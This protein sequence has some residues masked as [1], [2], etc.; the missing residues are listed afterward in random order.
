MAGLAVGGAAL[1]A[2]AA[3][4]GKEV[5]LTIETPGQPVPLLQDEAGRF[6][7][8][9]TVEGEVGAFIASWER[10]SDGELWQPKHVS[11]ALQQMPRCLDHEWRQILKPFT[12]KRQM[13]RSKKWTWKGERIAGLADKKSRAALDACVDVWGEAA[14][15]LEWAADKKSLTVTI[16]VDLVGPGTHEVWITTL[17]RKKHRAE[18]AVGPYYLVSMER[19]VFTQG[20]TAKITV[21]VPELPFDRDTPDGTPA[22]SRSWF[23]PT[24]FSALTPLP[25]G[26]AR[27]GAAATDG[28][29][30]GDTAGARTGGG[31]VQAE[32]APADDGTAKAKAED[33]DATSTIAV[34][35]V[36]PVVHAAPVQETAGWVAPRQPANLPWAA[37]GGLAL[38]LL[39]AVPS[40]LLER[41]AARGD[42]RL[43]RL[44]R[45]SYAPPRQASGARDGEPVDRLASAESTTTEG[46]DRA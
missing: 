38:A 12:S 3:K 4:D 33:D 36:T 5:R 39:V 7:F 46:E 31:D 32:E 2:T 18:G 26:P 34:G 15:D 24:S 1:P 37:V 28:A 11:L 21:E 20:P 22:G 23:A 41:G 19:N 6:F 35:K 30:D 45:A 14:A 9:V 42:G 40:W 13:M 16:P 17:D 44:V 10:M 29:G 27:G 43:S 8:R 25:W